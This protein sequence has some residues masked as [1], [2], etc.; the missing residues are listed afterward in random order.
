MDS[1][2]CFGLI[3]WLI[4]FDIDRYAWKIY[5]NRIKKKSSPRSGAGKFR[6]EIFHFRPCTRRSPEYIQRLLAW[7]L[8][9][10]SWE[11]TQFTVKV[12]GN[13]ATTQLFSLM[14]GEGRGGGGVKSQ[15]RVETPSLAPYLIHFSSEGVKRFG[16]TVVFLGFSN[17]GPPSP[18]EGNSRE[19]NNA[20]D[21]KK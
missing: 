7:I 1:K 14:R 3:C 16:G 21:V 20:R 12:S 11:N 15:P 5:E 19:I 4:L 18:K 2:G 8:S 17:W 9:F 10:Y 6:N 13:A